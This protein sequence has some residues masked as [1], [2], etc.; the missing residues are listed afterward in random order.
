MVR[1][2]GEDYLQNPRGG[3]YHPQEM[4]AGVVVG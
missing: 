4:L 1:G 2:C 3:A